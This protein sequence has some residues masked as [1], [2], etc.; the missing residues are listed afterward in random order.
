M[1]SEC[2]QYNEDL[3]DSICRGQK[4]IENLI[5]HWMKDHTCELAFG[6]DLEYEDSE[7]DDEN[8]SKQILDGANAVFLHENKP[9]NVIDLDVEKIR[10]AYRKVD[11]WFPP[12]M[13]ADTGKLRLPFE[14][15]EAHREKNG[16]K[17]LE[18][19][20]EYVINPSFVGNLCASFLGDRRA[21]IRIFHRLLPDRRYGAREYFLIEITQLAEW[22]G[23]EKYAVR[24]D[25]LLRYV[26]K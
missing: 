25:K 12:V 9:L 26:G 15:I 17:W 24:K 2:P 3:L 13:I 21:I 19:A 8:C 14:E 23:F 11:S 18:D 4:P 6:P 5:A 16:A 1:I 10:K 22:G 20:D 7:G